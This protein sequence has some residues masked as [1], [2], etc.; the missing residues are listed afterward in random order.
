MQI[1][2]FITRSEIKTDLEGAGINVSKNTISGAL[3]RIG[4]HSSSPR[5]VPLLKTKHVKDRLKFVETYEKKNMQFCEKGIWSNETKVELFGRNTATSVWRKNGIAFKKHNTISTVEFGGGSIMIW[6]C[7]SSKGTD[8]L[9]VI[10]GRMNRSMYRVILEKNLQKSA[11]SL[12]YGR[13][14]VLQHDNDPK[15]TA[16]RTKEWF[17]NNGISTLNW[18]SQSP[19]LNPIENLWN[20]LKAKVHKRNRPNIKQLKELC[21]EEWG[22]ITLDQCGKLVASYIL[23]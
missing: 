18:P 13:N 2:S 22:K 11:T 15:H 14:L 12:E 8:E 1:N 20:S 6:G 9:Q 16:K 7:F 23:N 3:Y 19:D 21:K 4:F 10:H 5:K 17:E